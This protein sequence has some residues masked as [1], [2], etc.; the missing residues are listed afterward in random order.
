MDAFVVLCLQVGAPRNTLTFY[1]KID[2]KISG[3]LSRRSIRV[4]SPGDITDEQVTTLLQAAMAAPSAMTKDPWRFV[5]VRSPESLRKLS[6]ML[7]GGGMLAAAARAIVVCGDLDA[8]FER[9][10]GYLVQDCSAATQNL[11]LAAD[12]IGLGACW[13]GVY[14]SEPAA[15]KVSDFLGLPGNVLPIAVI[16]LGLPGES[17]GARTRYNEAYV[18]RERW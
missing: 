1:M 10:V 4:Y 16:S 14:P 7:P 11:L 13:V 9:H 5:D 6:S 8:A 17:P 18:R 2:P 12:A 15:R 3:I